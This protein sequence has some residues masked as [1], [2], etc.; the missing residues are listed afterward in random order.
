MGE[1]P[2]RAGGPRPEHREPRSGDR[3]RSG[4]S[5]VPVIRIPEDPTACAALGCTETEDLLEVTTDE[6][7][8]VVCPDHVAGW[9]NR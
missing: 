5:E 1:S 4:P 2:A 7:T 9:V 8:R 3:P 6:G